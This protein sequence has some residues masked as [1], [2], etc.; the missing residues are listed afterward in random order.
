M[1]AREPMQ[2]RTIR[3]KSSEWENWRAAAER[4]ERVM[5]DWIRVQLNRAARKTD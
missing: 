3:M 2:N 1:S 4:D 5:S